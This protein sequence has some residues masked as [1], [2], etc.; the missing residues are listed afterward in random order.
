[1]TRRLATQVQQLEAL[2]HDYGPDAAK[3]AESLLSS[4]RHLR[5]ATP[6]S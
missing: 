6:I 2:R 5:F 1:M 3:R 4:M